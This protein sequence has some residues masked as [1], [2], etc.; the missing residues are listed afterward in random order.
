M[1]EPSYFV[2]SSA[3]VDNGAQV[4]AGTRIWHFCH[5]MSTAVLG[6]GCVLGQNVFVGAQ[7]TLGDRVKVQNNVSVYQGVTLEDDVFCGPS[8]VFTNVRNPRAHIERKDAFEP[9]RVGRGATLG[10]NCTVVCGNTVGAYAMVAAGSVVTRDV[11]DHA[12]VLGVPG[13]IAG[14]VCACGERLKAGSEQPREVIGC[15]F[16]ERQMEP[17]GAG[18]RVTE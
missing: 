10:A 14:W 15:G 7:C 3:I 5:V 17:A 4:G 9:T 16:C 8:M 2:H 18:L 6:E 13:R 1:A 12:L 11:P